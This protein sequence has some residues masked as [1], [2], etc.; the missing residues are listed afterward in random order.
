MHTSSHVQYSTRV[1]TSY[2]LEICPILT[3]ESGVFV[4]DVVVWYTVNPV[5][6]DCQ[7]SRGLCYF[8]GEICHAVY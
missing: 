2:R 5:L 6:R 4:W 3:T 1:L 8:V 7:L